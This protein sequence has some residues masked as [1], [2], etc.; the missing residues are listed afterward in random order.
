M[1]LTPVSMSIG[2][3]LESVPAAVEQQVDGG[4]DSGGGLRRR[5]CPRSRASACHVAGRAEHLDDRGDLA[6]RGWRRGPG[7]RRRPPP[8]RPCGAR[9]AAARR[10]RR[11]SGG[12]SSS[13]TTGAMV[14]KPGKTRRT[15]A[16]IAARSSVARRRTRCRSFAQSKTRAISAS[17]FGKW[18]YTRALGDAGRLGDAGERELLAAVEHARRRRR[19]PVRAR[20]SARASG[21]LVAGMAVLLPERQCYCQ[22]R[23]AEPARPRHAPSTPPSRGR[24]HDRPM[25]MHR[26]QRLVTSPTAEVRDAHRPARRRDVGRHDHGRRRRST[27]AGGPTGSPR[28][29]APTTSTSCSPGRS[30]TSTARRSSPLT[31]DEM[32]RRPRP[33]RRP[34]VDPR[35]AR[36]RHR[37]SLRSRF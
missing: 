5:P 12:A 32:E 35:R 21:R 33:A 2:S 22:P 34:R 24:P 20:G 30:S 14:S 18:R 25:W 37:R 11:P 26:T 17:R 13:V 10:A 27:T 31:L 9:R 29:R 28:R 4:R 36:R 1:W 15:I 19:A 23:R 8:R 6:R 7:R 16:V 3:L